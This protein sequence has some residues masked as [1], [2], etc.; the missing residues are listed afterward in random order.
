MSGR[1]GPVPGALPNLAQQAATPTTQEDL[2]KLRKS[3]GR[4]RQLNKTWK[5]TAE[6]ERQK[7]EMEK[8][9]RQRDKRPLSQAGQSDTKRKSRSRSRPRAPGP[10]ASLSV[11]EDTPGEKPKLKWIPDEREEYPVHL[12]E[13]K[14]HSFIAWEKKYDLDHR[15]DEVQ[16]LRYLVNFREV[17]GKVIS[18]LHWS[19]VYG[20]MGFRHPVPDQIVG[21]GFM[22]RDWQ[23]PPNALFPVRY[24]QL[25]DI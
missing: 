19:L 25:V 14:M 20:I 9:G 13:K 21:L 1:L 24:A 3:D 7:G 22:D 8:R 18:R 15:C 4:S 17:T 10:K 16:A 2:N 23:T 12:V 11:T 6:Y 5:D